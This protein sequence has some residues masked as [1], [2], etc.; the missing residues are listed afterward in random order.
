MKVTGTVKTMTLGLWLTCTCLVMV[1]SFRGVSA[2]MGGTL[3]GR[4]IDVASGRGVDNALV[5][6]VDGGSVL[7]DTTGF[8]LLQS[9]AAGRRTVRVMRI[10]FR[11]QVQE[12]LVK[13]GDSAIL[14]VALSVTPVELREV[15]VSDETQ[16]QKDIREVR[17]RPFSVSVI[18]ATRLAGRGLTLDEALQRATGMQV[19]RS[20]GLG[21]ASIF[22]VRGLEG[23]RVQ[24]YVDG[25]AVNVSGSAFSLD[26]IPMALVERVEIYKGVVPARFGGDGLGAAV[27]V[28]IREF[29]GGYDDASY[30]FGSYGQHQVSTLLLRRPFPNLEVGVS[31]NFDMAANDYRMESPF[32]PGLE[33]KR[34]HD[35]FRRMLLGSVLSYKGSWFDEVHLEGAVI[36]SQRELQGIQTNLQHAETGSRFVVAVLDGERQGALGGRLDLRLGAVAFQT[37]VGLVDTSSVRYTFEGDRYPSPNGR[38]ELAT[39]PAHSDNRTWGFRHRGALTYRF[40]PEHHGNLVYTFDH[41]RFAPRDTLANRYAGGNVSEFPGRK[42][43]LVVGLS[44]EWPR[45]DDLDGLRCF[46]L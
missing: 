7:T 9:V 3:R 26:N 2:Q 14:D 31:A 45:I 33:I 27:N 29:P 36:G 18:N 11:E 34:D 6:I 5:S 21:S 4:V 46:R 32:I 10:G 24:I 8:Y 15:T 35:G 25:N 1:G 23:N 16:T 19:R 42:T 30:T 40:A 37:K 39:L 17:Q 20:G 12:V 43:N 22:H 13:G 28:V 44:H 41:S 38:G